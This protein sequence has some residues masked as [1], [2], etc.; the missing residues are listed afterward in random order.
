MTPF[1]IIVPA[2]NCAGQLETLL[3][4]LAELDYPK[5]QYEILVVNDGSSD[6][7]A[8]VME[9]YQTSAI[10]HPKNLGRVSARESGAKGA[11]FDTLVFIDARLEIEP[12]LLKNAHELNYLPLMGV[13]KSDK[14]LSTIDRVFYCI[15]RRTYH[16]Y[17][18]QHKYNEELWL[19]PG[20][21]DGRPKGTGLLIIE[22]QMFLDCAWK[23]KD[24]M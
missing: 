11:K 21:F 12:D 1:S 16:P 3:K 2:Y 13:G 19:R 23:T 5:D 18:P 8:K 15:R 14:T 22:R 24:K 20:E 6:D 4:Q 17:E 7:T 10:H 9:K